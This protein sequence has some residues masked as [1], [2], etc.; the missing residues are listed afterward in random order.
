M[1]AGID[2]LRRA[3]NMVTSTIQTVLTQQ[4][5]DMIP[6]IMEN[7]SREMPNRIMR[8]VLTMM[9][10]GEE[11]DRAGRIVTDTRNWMEG[12]IRVSG[13]RSARQQSEIEAYYMGVADMQKDAA[14][15][16]RVR[17]AVRTAA[18]DGATVDYG[19]F[20]EDYLN[21]G[22]NPTRYGTWVKQNLRTA[23]EVRTQSSLRKSMAAPSNR[24]N[25]WRYQAYGAWPVSA[26]DRANAGSLR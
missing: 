22:G 20:F 26:E 2:V 17:T 18:R 3:S 7:V 6:V 11:V 25:A 9:N 13:V 21:A 10:E 8:G 14:R 4:P 23:T 12:V 19:R 15:M 16:E 1:P 24:L 5:E